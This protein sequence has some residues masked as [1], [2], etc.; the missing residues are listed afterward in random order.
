MKRTRMLSLVLAA[1]LLLCSCSGTA[2]VKENKEL[3]DNRS[4]MTRW[5]GEVRKVT[6]ASQT[7]Q[8]GEDGPIQWADPAM[9]AHIRFILGKPEGDILRSEVWNIQVLVLRANQPNGFDVALEQPTEGDTFTSDLETDRSIRHDYNGTTFGNLT[10]LSDLRYFDSLQYFDYSGM[11]PYDGPTDLSG[12]EACTALKNFELTGAKPASLEPLAGLQELE[13]L[14]LSSCGTLDLTPLAGL[15]E[16]TDLSLNSDVLVSLEP[17]ATLP[18]LNY[19]SIGV[20]TTYPSLE[21]LTQTK[22]GFLNMGQAVGGEKLY[23]GMDY[24]PLTRMPE[25]Q[26]L[27]LTNNFDVTVELCRQ[28]AAG[29]PKLRGL[30]ISYT[31]AADHGN[32][33]DDLGIEWLY[34]IPLNKDPVGI[35]RRFLYRL[36]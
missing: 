14:S 13:S 1:A 31:P 5:V 4:E 27:D 35:W 21:P 12:V 15:P 29:S 9:E 11:A 18:K 3:P 32:E 36:A 17:L 24:E 30:N 7:A 22:L 10:T 8:H 23:K 28:I 33:L 19:L 16:L 2:A 25:L 26:Y 34:D 20:G 6:V